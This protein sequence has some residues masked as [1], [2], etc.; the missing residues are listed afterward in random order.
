[1]LRE[2]SCYDWDRRKLR[3]RLLGI[4]ERAIEPLRHRPALARAPGIVLGVVSRL[5]TIK[6]FPQLFSLLSPVIAEH[7]AFHLDIFGAGGYASVRDLRRALAPIRERVRFCGAQRNVGAAYRS[8]DYLLTGLPEKEALG[9]NVIE[10]IATGCPVLGV[11]APPFVETIAPE[12]TGLLYRDPREDAGRDFDRLLTRLE[13]SPFMID[14]V[15]AAPEIDRFSESRF[16]ARIAR[17][18]EGVKGLGGPS[19]A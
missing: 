13:T 16:D 17:L 14:A 4:A 15:R 5:T 12:A 9:L 11:D 3:D 10:A 2:T 1:M 6:Q 8:I 7:P 19:V 18:L